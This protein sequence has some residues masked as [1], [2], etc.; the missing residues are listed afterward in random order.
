LMKPAGEKLGVYLEGI[1]FGEAKIPLIN[2]VDVRIETDPNSI[3]ESLVRQAASP[4]RWAE[5]IR[6]M[7][8]QGVTHVVECGPGKVLAGLV[9]RID[10]RVQGMAAADRSS[11]EQ[12]LAA[13][14]GG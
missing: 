12:A 10:A 3:K 9:K 8:E 7:A 1:S 5:I 13:T 6:A 2:N 11:L 14:K 4:V